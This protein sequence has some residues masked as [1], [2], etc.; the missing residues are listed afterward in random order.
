M[1]SLSSPSSSPSPATTPAQAQRVLVLQGGGALGSYQAGAYQSLCRHDFEPDWVAGISIG[2][3]NS[4]IIA[5]NPREKRQARLREFWELVSSPVPWQPLIGGDRA[6]LAFNE[7]SAALIATFGVPGFFMP[8]VPPALLW[9]P[10]SEQSL[11]FYDTAPLR[12]TLER[13]VDF[14]RI[15]ARKTRLSVGAVNV[16]T[17]NF[18]YFDNTR[19]EIRPEHIM[20]SGALP[21]GFPAV[22]IDGEFYWDGGVASNTPLDY[23][24]DEETRA[25][26][27]IFQVDLF[28]ARGRLPSTLLEAS[29]REKDIRY[30]SRTRLNTDMNKKIHNTRLA[31]RNLIAKLPANLKNDPDVALLNEAAKENTVTVVHLIYKSKNFETSSKD[32]DFSNFAM[33]E[34][35]AA[36]EHD[37]DCS[38]R[39]PEW[40]Q[41]PQ[42][43]ETMVT[44][45]LIGDEPL[46]P[47]DT[48]E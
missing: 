20:A 16:R 34:H 21:P 36:G 24:L 41:R 42:N 38:M 13:L 48:K 43:G 26:L 31:L 5:G 6:R 9:P 8:R 18:T 29:E 2:A 25:D 3:I 44:Y 30:S 22:E 35:W 37:V 12:E 10:G 15:N 7:T 23:V 45:D 19:Q 11:S 4:A 17:G 28:S 27:L 39:H 1:D 46:M 32:Y 40:L 47:D 14:D 33:R